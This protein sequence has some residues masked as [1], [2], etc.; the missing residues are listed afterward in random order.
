MNYEITSHK[1][2]V[3]LN[4]THA[5]GTLF[6]AC[7][8]ICLGLGSELQERAAGLRYPSPLLG[9]IST[10]SAYPVIILEAK[11][12]TQL[13]NFLSR[14]RENLDVSCNLFTTSMIGRSAVDQIACTAALTAETADIVAV[15]VFGERSLVEFATK[16]FSL[17]KGWPTND[18][19]AAQ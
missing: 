10:I 18:V 4:R 5:L 9:L 14:T 15:G 11:S 1:F 13:V 8:H 12:S 2:V 6:N 3:I 16:K 19:E 7:A 17:Y